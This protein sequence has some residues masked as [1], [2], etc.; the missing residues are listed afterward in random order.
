MIS[1]MDNWYVVYCRPRQEERASQHLANQGFN[2]FLPRFCVM[3]EAQS[4]TSLKQ[5][6]LLF[7]RYLFVQPKSIDSGCWAS[8]RSTRGVVDFV[9]FGGRI[10][11]VPTRVLLAINAQ[12]LVQTQQTLFQSGDVVQLTDGIYQGINAIYQA[13]VGDA[14]SLLLIKLLQQDVAITVADSEFT[15]VAGS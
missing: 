8:V 13:S 3:Q 11:V 6:E 9:R 4:S 2:T 7:P 14:R 12:Q 10:A 1:H 5:K 15:K